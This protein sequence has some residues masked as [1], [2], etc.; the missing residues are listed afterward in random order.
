MNLFRPKHPQAS[1]HLQP[2][3]HIPLYPKRETLL[4]LAEKTEDREHTARTF[5]LEVTLV[6]N[7]KG[8]N[9]F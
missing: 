2:L 4:P 7:L 1:P 5:F 8:E 6:V 3:E 9:I